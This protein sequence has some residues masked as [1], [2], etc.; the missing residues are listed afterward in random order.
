MLKYVDF[1][2]EGKKGSSISGQVMKTSGPQHLSVDHADET[3]EGL[4]RKL[5]DHY[6]EKVKD[7]EKRKV[8]NKCLSTYAYALDKKLRISSDIVDMLAKIAGESSKETIE[9]L[10]KSTE[11]YFDKPNHYGA[12]S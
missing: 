2:Q 4:R 3:L 7:A 5:L 8:I 10:Q 11:E 6:F 12:T 9:Y 1:L